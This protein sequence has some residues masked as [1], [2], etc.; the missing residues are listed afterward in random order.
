MFDRYQP[1]D[2]SIRQMLRDGLGLKVSSGDDLTSPASAE[3]LA[4]AE[5]I[6]SEKDS[7]AALTNASD[8]DRGEAGRG[9][10]PL[11]D[12]RRSILQGYAGAD[13]AG[14]RHVLSFCD[15]AARCYRTLCLEH[16]AKANAPPRYWC[17]RHLT[18]RHSR[19]FWYFSLVCT[20][21]AAANNAQADDVFTIRLL[22]ELDRP[23][24]LRLFR[25]VDER[26]RGRG[27]SRP[28]AVR[29]VPRFPVGAAAPRLVAKVE[30]ATRQRVD[31]QN[32]FPAVQFNAERLHHVDPIE[33]QETHVRRRLFS[34]FL[35]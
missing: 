29:L 16:K 10:C 9:G 6:G 32:P 18:L 5:L 22:E 12:V 24:Y 11:A 26:H 30:Y 3:E 21:V 34:W 2:R 33:S 8:V 14:G 35:L 23:P 13:R 27:G 7:A 19:K 1:H 4:A 20:V 15:D 31:L 17:T 25:A 28:G